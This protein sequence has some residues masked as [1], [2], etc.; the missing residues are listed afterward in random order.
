[1]VRGHFSTQQYSAERLL[2]LSGGLPVVQIALDLDTD[3]T[4]IRIAGIDG[5]AVPPPLLRVG[6]ALTGETR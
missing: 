2:A 1:M 3:R 4:S 6:H 5:D